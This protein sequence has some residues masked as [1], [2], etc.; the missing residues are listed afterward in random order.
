MRKWNWRPLVAVM[1]AVSFVLFAAG[2]SQQQE[3]AKQA[4]TE[5]SAASQK[6]S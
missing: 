6:E 4:Q 3:P 5:S 2:C 1:M